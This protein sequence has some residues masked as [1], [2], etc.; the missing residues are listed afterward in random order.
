MWSMLLV[1][2]EKCVGCR[3]CTMY[4]SLRKTRTCNPARS[5]VSVIAWEEQGIMVPAMCQHCQEPACALVCPANAIRKDPGTGLVA[6]DPDRCIH[7]HMCI[8]ACPFGGPS[9]DTVEGKVIR[10]DLCQGEEDGKTDQY[11]PGCAQQGQ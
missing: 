10:C 2:Y 4:C 3:L 8:V 7:C 9:I 5:R 6:T 11:V 1:D